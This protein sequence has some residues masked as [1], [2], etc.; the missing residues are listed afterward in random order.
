MLV[1]SA[2]AD[3]DALYEKVGRAGDLAPNVDA[4]TAQGATRM[5]ATLWLGANSHFDLRVEF[6][7]GAASHK[8]TC[9]RRRRA[10]C[11]CRRCSTCL[12][13]TAVLNLPDYSRRLS[14]RTGSDT[15]PLEAPRAP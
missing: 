1:V 8:I 7:S 3:V 6:K 4:W 12:C 5:E 15:G 10:F 9:R 14:K 2:F 11:N 13:I